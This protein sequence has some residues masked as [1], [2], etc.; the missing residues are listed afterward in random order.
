MRKHPIFKLGSYRILRAEGG[1]FIAIRFDEK[2]FTLLIINRDSQ[3]FEISLDLNPYLHRIQ[4]ANLSELFTD[5][6]NKIDESGYLKLN[7]KPSDC[8]LLISW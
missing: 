8:Q 1:T 2:D 7:L 5:H 6:Q 4:R 3:G